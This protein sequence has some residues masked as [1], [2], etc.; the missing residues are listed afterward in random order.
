MATLGDP[1]G[2]CER[3]LSNRSC[4]L[5]VGFVGDGPGGGERPPHEGGHAGAQLCAG[6]GLADHP[7][8]SDVI[9][10]LWTN[11]R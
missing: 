3:H 2:V 5:R 11:G 10:R 8:D 6:E 1:C 4:I 7:G 9:M